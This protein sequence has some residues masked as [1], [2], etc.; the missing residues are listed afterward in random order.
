MLLEAGWNWEPGLLVEEEREREIERE[1][2]FS[3]LS[4]L[5]HKE[6]LD[7]VGLGGEWLRIG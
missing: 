1:A 7:D 4:P 3:N 5:L 2:E 6:L